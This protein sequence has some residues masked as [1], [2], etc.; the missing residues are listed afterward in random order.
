MHQAIQ[1]QLKRA[2]I[3]SVVEVVNIYIARRVVTLAEV[4][5]AGLESGSHCWVE[6]CLPEDSHEHRLMAGDAERGR[7]TQKYSRAS[8]SFAADEPSQFQRSAR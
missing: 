1:D 2:R 8:N 5:L 6:G 3:S 7:D 4:E